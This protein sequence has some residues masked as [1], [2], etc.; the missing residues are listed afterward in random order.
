MRI[1][2]FFLILFQIVYCS[3][4]ESCP[5][6]MSEI[7]RKFHQRVAYT[8][9]CGH[10]FC[11][12]C[13]NEMQMRNPKRHLQNCALC[14]DPLN[15]AAREYQIHYALR[16]YESY[17]KIRRLFKQCDNT[18]ERKF[19]S[20]RVAERL[21]K[22]NDYEQMQMLIEK[23]IFDVNAYDWE[24]NTALMVA[25]DSRKL[26]FVKLLV[27]QGANV[28]AMNDC[29]YTA[30]HFA[31]LQGDESIV[32]ALFETS[33]PDINAKNNNRET[34]LMLAIEEGHAEVVKNLLERGA[35]PNLKNVFGKT[36]FDLARNKKAILELL[37]N[38]TDVKRIVEPN[39]NC[40]MNHSDADKKYSKNHVSCGTY[41]DMLKIL[42]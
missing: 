23:N 10:Q 19:Q 31:A 6:C 3:E 28:Q 32:D 2:E 36:A 7:G 25:A 22:N 4:I 16:D 29:Q 18:R 9:P 26:D 5:I 11:L 30:L 21:I 13:M 12:D 24:Q 39:A 37:L 41:E 15:E 20:Q 33:R 35:N 40:S 38:I 27:E 17:E 14:R 34:P 1:F 8:T 42:K